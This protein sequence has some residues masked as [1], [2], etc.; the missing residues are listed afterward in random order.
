MAPCTTSEIELSRE[1]AGR[2]APGMLILA[3]R[4][5]DGFRLC[6]QAAATGAALLWRVK[7]NSA[8]G[9]GRLSL[10]GPGWRRSPR[11]QAPGAINTTLDLDY[12]IDDGG[13]NPDAYRLQTTIPDPAEA[14][15]EDLAT[16][17][18]NGRRLSPCSTD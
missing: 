17:T 11:P 4:G 14:S 15:A 5:F 18:P 7:T 8:I 10:T 16:C 6:A 2:F 9:V 12:T 13:D 1:L 3:D